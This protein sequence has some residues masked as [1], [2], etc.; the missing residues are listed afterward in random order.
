MTGALSTDYLTGRPYGGVGFIWRKTFG[1]RVSFL[2][3]NS[4]KRCIAIKVNISDSL[5]VV[6]VNA[7][8]LVLSM[9]LS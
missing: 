6:I 9:L 3:S 1:N 5:A 4:A 8:Q 7:F 2:G